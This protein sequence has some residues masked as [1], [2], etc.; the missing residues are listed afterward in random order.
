MPIYE[1]ECRQCGV[2]FEKWQR[3]DDPDPMA[4]PNGHTDVH[5]LLSPP[6][7]IFKG[8]G[9]YATDHGR[10]GSGRSAPKKHSG[11]G[12]EPAASS[13]AEDAGES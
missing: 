12:S 5:R 9:F 10:N 1:Y 4:C 8:S 13:K 11:K 7:I 6:A 2:H 3:Y